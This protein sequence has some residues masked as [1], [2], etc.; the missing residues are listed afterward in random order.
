MENYE[1]LRKVLDAALMQA[2]SGKGFERHAEGEPFEDQIMM[3][4]TSKFGIGFPLGQA[5]KKLHE[6]QRLEPDAAI[7]E[8]LGAINY[9]AGVVIKL[10]SIIKEKDSTN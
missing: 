8:C 9:I 3:T 6:A 5:V 4:I 10:K 2:S 7:R 1:S